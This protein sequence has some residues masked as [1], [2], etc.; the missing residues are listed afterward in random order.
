MSQRIIVYDNP[1]ETRSQK[2]RRIMY[3]EQHPRTLPLSIVSREMRNMAND[4]ASEFMRVA[5]LYKDN[6][7]QLDRF[8]RTMDWNNPESVNSL[9]HSW[10]REIT[11]SNKLYTLSTEWSN[12]AQSYNQI[13]NL[14][15][16]NQFP[17][18][19]QKLPHIEFSQL[20]NRPPPPEVIALLEE[21]D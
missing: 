20:A 5:E 9:F 10:K 19:L 14:S 15:R 4:K 7:Q 12:Y 2:R 17:G 3:E 13:K 21:E 11:L 8:F 16:M 1:K 18:E 6:T